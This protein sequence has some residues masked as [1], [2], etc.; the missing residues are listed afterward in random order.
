[1]KE[2]DRLSYILNSCNQCIIKFCHIQWRSQEGVLGVKSFPF[3]PK[4]KRVAK[5]EKLRRKL[6][7][8]TPKNPPWRPNPPCTTFFRL[9]LKKSSNFY[10]EM[11]KIS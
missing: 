10:G 2:K 11:N 4:K 1:M 5:Y 9:G 7:K 3:G 8:M 6:K